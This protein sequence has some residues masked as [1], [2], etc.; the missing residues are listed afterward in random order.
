MK[1]LLTQGAALC[2]Y[3]LWNSD[4]RPDNKDIGKDQYVLA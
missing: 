4:Y 2:S 3:C 1:K